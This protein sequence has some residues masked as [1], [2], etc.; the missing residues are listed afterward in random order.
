MS[1]QASRELRRKTKKQLRQEAIA[2]SKLREPASP[3]ER[4][5]DYLLPDPDYDI[6]RNM[7]DCVPGGLM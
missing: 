1:Y 4:I 7:L 5:T 2:K 3:E 6:S